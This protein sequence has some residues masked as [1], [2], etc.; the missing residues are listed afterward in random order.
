MRT[1]LSSC[2]SDERHKRQLGYYNVYARN[3]IGLVATTKLLTSRTWQN[4]WADVKI[5][6]EYVRAILI[7]CQE[8]DKLEHIKISIVRTNGL[9]KP[10]HS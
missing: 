1:P 7:K 10:P 8:S 4:N 6:L 5:Y 2:D 9:S 3:Y